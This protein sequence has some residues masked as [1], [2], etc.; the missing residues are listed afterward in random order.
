MADWL[1]RLTY[2]VV[3]RM[4][5]LSHKELMRAMV[6]AF[7]RA[8]LPLAYSQGYHPHPRLSFGPPRSTGMAA[9]NEQLD[10]RL[11]EPREPAECTAAL[12]RELPNGL[13]IV[14]AEELDPRAPSITASTRAG[15]YACA[16]P[17]G[18]APPTDSICRLLAQTEISCARTAGGGGRE[19][20]LRPGV[21]DIRWQPPNVAMHLALSPGLHVRPQEVLAA[22]SGWPDDAVRRIIVTRTGQE[23]APS[24]PGCPMEMYGPRNSCRHPGNSGTKDSDCRGHGS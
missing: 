13:R 3:G 20:N 18:A 15:H 17:A 7:R 21:Y 9:T 4:R 14:R 22:L 23:I 6:R 10:A 1:Y 5:F 16:W 12:D 8:R 24:E 19:V 2:E 11:T